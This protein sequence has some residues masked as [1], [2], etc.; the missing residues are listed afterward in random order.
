VA[1]SRNMG[2][3]WTL[4][5][6]S[7]RRGAGSVSFNFD[8]FMEANPTD[9]S[10]WSSINFFLLPKKRAEISSAKVKRHTIKAK[11]TQKPL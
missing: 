2:G 1:G 6:F 11:S 4:G 10:R 7:L 5:A 3:V 9:K 8:V